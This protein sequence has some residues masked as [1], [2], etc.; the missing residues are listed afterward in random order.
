MFDK[1]AYHYRNVRACVLP[2]GI[3]G[4]DELAASCESV[5]NTGLER[6]ALA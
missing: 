6:G 1:R 4:C 2:V 5:G 3:K